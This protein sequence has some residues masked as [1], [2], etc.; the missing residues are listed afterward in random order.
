MP[1]DMDA[2]YIHEQTGL[3][4]AS[5]HAGR[6]HTCGHD[7]HAAGRS[8]HPDF[9]GTVHFIFQ[10]AEGL[11]GTSAMLNDGLLERFPCDA[12]YGLHNKPGIPLGTFALRAGLMLCASDTW[13]VVFRDTGGHG[14][15][16]AHLSI[17]PTLPAAQFI[18]ALQAIVSRNV[19]AMESAVLSIGHIQAVIPM[20]RTSFPTACVSKAR[21]AAIRP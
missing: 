15:S 4:Y 7:G 8:V 10:P 16:G 9:A 11:G 18:R 1:I 13:Q 19:P 14:R 20:H 6:I 5:A 3:P 17:D 21:G 12:I 2:L